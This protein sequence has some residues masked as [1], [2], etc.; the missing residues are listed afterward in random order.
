ML[1]APLAI[2]ISA[3][4]G[5]TALAQTP[6]PAG[7]PA[8]DQAQLPAS[9]AGLGRNPDPWEPLNRKLYGFFQAIDPVLFRP[10]AIFYK[11]A[12]PRPVRTGLRNAFSNL[13]EPVIFINDMAQFHFIDAGTTFGR[14]AVNSTVGL[15]GLFDPATNL[16]LAYHANGFG[17][18]LGRYGVPA[19]P[20]LFIPVAGPS[21]LRDV[22]G[23]GLDALSDPLTWIRF[24][25]RWEVNAGRVVITGLDQRANS[26]AQLKQI[27][28]MATDPYATIRSLYLQNRKAEITGGQ[29]NV[30]SLPDFGDEAG[31]AGAPSSPT[32]NAP[33]APAAPAQA[34]PAD[35]SPTALQTDPSQPH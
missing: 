30:N 21:D 19:G 24:T 13:R 3:L 14:L 28:S 22:I 18:T 34:A 33:G 5:G 15:A 26:D 7:P 6:A 8:Q 35:Q 20:Y 25:G 23:V 16:G 9:T 17:T 11:R 1:R 32:G 27:N 10:P 4:L 31:A 29:V 12:T 2:A